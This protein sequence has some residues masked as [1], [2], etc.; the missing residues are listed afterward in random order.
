M[1]DPETG[2]K[3]SINVLKRVKELLQDPEIEAAILPW[4]TASSS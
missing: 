4:K 2:W 1:Q 3:A